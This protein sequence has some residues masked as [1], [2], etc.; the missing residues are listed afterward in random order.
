MEVYIRSTQTPP[1][2]CFINLTFLTIVAAS[3]AAQN[4]ISVETVTDQFGSETLWQ[5]SGWQNGVTHIG[6]G[7]ADFDEPGTYPQWNEQ[8]NLPNGFYQFGLISGEDGLCCGFG[9]GYVTVRHVASGLILFQSDSSFTSGDGVFGYFTLPPGGVLG[10]LFLDDDQDCEPGTNELR[11]PHRIIE[12]LPGP[13]YAITDSLGRFSMALPPGQYT[14]GVVSSGLVPICPAASPVPFEITAI[15]P[16]PELLLGDSST[17]TLDIITTAA[18]GPAR[19]GFMVNMTLRVSNGSALTSGP[20]TANVQLD[21]LVTYADASI[22]PQSIAGNSI[23]WQL[24]PLGPYAQRS[25]NIRGTLPPDPQIIGQGIGLLAAAIQPLQ[26]DVLSNNTYMAHGVITGSYDP[27]DKVV[28]PRDLYDLATDSVLDY[29]IRFQNTGTDTAF[30][31]VIT[32][33]LAAEFDMATFAAGATSHPAVLAFKPG[34][35][36]EWRF[37]NILLP[38]S[39]VNEPA[40]HGYVSFRIRPQEPV[41]PGTIFV[42]TA[43][44]YFDFNPPVITEPSVLLAEFNTALR[45]NAQEHIRLLP[46]PVSE[47]LTLIL[48]AGT[49]AS[50]VLLSSDGQHLN[51]PTTRSSDGLRLD[52]RSL[53]PGVYTVRSSTGSARFVKQ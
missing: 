46:N 34:R 25:I 3:A 45:E 40:S 39:N 5:I 12:V 28:W 18:I 42:N 21:P 11:V 32:D 17:A 15:N 14:A 29:T 44:I 4:Q 16:I 10:T 50:F 8:F 22:A 43:N 53:A 30:N 38:D 37:D 33:T 48:P 51:V 26:E 7:F 20:I 31:V 1:M 23:T 6:S 47:Q 19:P 13:E 24:P 2:R 27:N 49:A 9:F 36:L 41:I 52:V 35:V